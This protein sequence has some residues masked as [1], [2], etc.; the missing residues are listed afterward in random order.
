V[1]PAAAELAVALSFFDT[2]AGIHGTVRSGLTLLFEGREARAERAPAEIERAGG[3]WQAR[4]AGDVD[5]N[6]TPVSDTADLGGISVSVC[7][8]EGTVGGKKISGLGTAAET[9]RPPE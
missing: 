9:H 1:S 2:D 6:V 8:V 7:S 5:I 4:A 3:G